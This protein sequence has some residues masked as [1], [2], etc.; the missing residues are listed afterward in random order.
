MPDVLWR[1]F[2]AAICYVAF[3]F[4]VPLFLAVLDISVTGPLWALIRAL[5]AFGAIAY[6]IWGRHTYPWA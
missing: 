3:V 5:A 4:I 6:V 2:V 1:L